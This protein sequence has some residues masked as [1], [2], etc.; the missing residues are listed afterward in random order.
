MNRVVAIL[1]TMYNP[2][3]EGRRA[4]RWFTISRDNHSGKRLY[5]LT[6]DKAELLVTNSCP[7]MGADANSHGTPDPHWLRESLDKIDEIK[8]IRVI[9]VCGKV[10]QKTYRESKF[11]ATP[12]MSVIEILHPA[13]RTWTK[14]SIKDTQELIRYALHQY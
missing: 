13:A 5:K 7:R 6:G 12:D 1:D 14:Q 10:A 8:I 9:L 4:P 2:G 11:Y 3:C